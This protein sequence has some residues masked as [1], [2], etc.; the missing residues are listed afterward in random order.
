MMNSKLTL[1][2]LELRVNLGWPDKERLQE[3]VVLLDIEIEFPETPKACI[4]DNLADTLCYSTL[5]QHIRA[6][7]AAKNFYLIEHLSYEIYQLIQS[8]LPDSAK[9]NVRI[10]KHPNIDGLLGGVSFA[11]GECES[12][13]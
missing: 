5:T 13:W 4:T 8:Q 1:R 2:N 10:T 9:M 11:Y 6:N 3:Q 12:S 7:I